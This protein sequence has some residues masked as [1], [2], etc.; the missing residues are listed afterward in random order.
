MEKN[1]KRYAKLLRQIRPV[2]VRRYGEDKTA[3]L[4]CDMEPIYDQRL[5][6]LAGKRTR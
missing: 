6:R 2:L 1:E 5:P 4:L 3:K